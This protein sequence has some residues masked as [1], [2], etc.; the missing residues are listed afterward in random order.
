MRFFVSSN[1]KKNRVLFHGVVAFMVFALLFWLASWVH[2][3]SRY[4]FSSESLKA[5]FFIDPELGERVS[6]AQISED[7]HVGVFLH[8]MLLIVLLSLFN[9]TRWSAGFKL[10]LAGALSLLAL[11][12]VSC[13][14][15]VLLLGPAF[16]VV[17]LLSFLAYQAVFLLLWVLT[18][19]G[20]FTS[21]GNRPPDSS[22][23]MLLGLFA[24]FSL[25]F[26]LSNF[27]NF[28]LKM[29]FSPQGVKDYL[30]GN[31]ELYVK[32]KS[33]EGLFKVFYPHLLG[34]ALYA[35]ALS[36]LLPFAG[37]KRKTSLLFGLFM[38]V[39][40]FVENSSGFLVLYAGPFFAH[41]KLLSFWA[42]QVVA[43]GCTCLLLVASL[44]RERSSTLYL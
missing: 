31:P 18:L 3:Y 27:L 5:Y 32:G 30:L 9:L 14:F 41:V 17:K 25:I 20:L 24:V 40:S 35:L 37:I 16:A 10:F 4:G 36:H 33:S 29:G 42:F 26:L 19:Y 1:I 7:F 22:L 38:F 6:L 23:R 21:P 28:F 39:F 43:V 8:G 15:L 13:D 2:F 44:R 12:Y 11:F 34:M